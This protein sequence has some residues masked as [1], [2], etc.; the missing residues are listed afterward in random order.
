MVP[1]LDYGLYHTLN[2]PNFQSW[3]ITSRIDFYCLMAFDG[4]DDY[5]HTLAGDN[6]IKLTRWVISDNQIDNSG[7]Y[8]RPTCKCSETFWRNSVKMSGQCTFAWRHN[9]TINQCTA[10]IYG[11]TA[12]RWPMSSFPLYFASSKSMWEKGYLDCTKWDFV[13]CGVVSND[14]H[15]LQ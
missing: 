3:K 12:F 8:I 1:S 9:T 7:K 6:P 4:T 2:I 5:S 10:S 13:T 14:F 11:E 15:S